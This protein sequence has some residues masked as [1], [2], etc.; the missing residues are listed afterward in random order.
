MKYKHLLPK[1]KFLIDIKMDCECEGYKRLKRDYEILL[2]KQELKDSIKEIEA[3]EKKYIDDLDY[4][5]HW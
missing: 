4:N 1:P 2:L 3:K 5:K